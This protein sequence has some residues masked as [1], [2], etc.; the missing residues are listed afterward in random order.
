MTKPRCPINVFIDSDGPVADFDSAFQK[1]GLSVHDFKYAPGTYLWLNETPGASAAL[2][3]LKAYDDEDLIRIW[4]LTK[5]P[6]QSPYAYSEKILWYR[7]HFPW[8]EDRVILTHDKSLMG[9]END[10]LIDDRPHKANAKDFRGTFVKFDVQDPRTSWELFTKQ[11]L[12][13]A[14][15]FYA[16]NT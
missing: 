8:L 7:E 14:T 10:F 13:F 16:Q 9:A 6:S 12:A 15:S 2:E 4:I 3:E 5:T 11:V 1:S